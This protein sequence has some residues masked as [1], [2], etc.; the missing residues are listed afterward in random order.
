LLKKGKGYERVE[1]RFEEIKER[2]GLAVLG[3]IG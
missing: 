2:K 3:N 1:K